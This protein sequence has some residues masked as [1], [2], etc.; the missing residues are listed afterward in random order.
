M[1]TTITWAE[2]WS[3]VEPREELWIQLGVIIFIILHGAL[4]LSF[5]QL[6]E[7]LCSFQ[8]FSSVLLFPFGDLFSVKVISLW[9]AKEYLWL[10]PFLHLQRSLLTI[11]LFADEVSFRAVLL[12]LVLWRVTVSPSS[13]STSATFSGRI[14]Y[15]FSLEPEVCQ[16]GPGFHVKIVH[17]HTLM[18][19]KVAWR[20][21]LIKLFSQVA[22]LTWSFELLEVFFCHPLQPNFPAQHICCA[23]SSWG[24][25]LW[26]RRT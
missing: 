25:T 7:F 4:F 24:N 2:T 11:N 26:L 8:H 5:L 23:P 21:S 19:V 14:P 6:K 10:L 1:H 12:K 16:L 22:H 13:A 9:A 17:F 15:F 20:I 18:L 3:L